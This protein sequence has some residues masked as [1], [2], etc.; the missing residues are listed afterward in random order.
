MVA[1]LDE[2][3]A[4]Q[5]KGDL[6]EYTEDSW[7]P[8][9]NAA[10][11]NSRGPGVWY[12]T[13]NSSDILTIDA[14]TG[15]LLRSVPMNGEVGH[16]T[17]GSF[18][19]KDGKVYTVIPYS[20]NEAGVFSVDPISGESRKLFSFAKASTDGI[21]ICVGRVWND[22]AHLIFQMSSDKDNM[23]VMDLQS[24][25]IVNRVEGFF[26][27]HVQD[28]LN[29][30]R[31]LAIQNMHPG[32]KLVS[33]DPL[34]GDSVDLFSMNTTTLG[35]DLCAQDQAGFAV[36]TSGQILWFLASYNDEAG[37]LYR[38]VF[39]LELATD[40]SSAALTSEYGPAFGQGTGFFFG[41]LDYVSYMTDMTV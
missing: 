41:R 32:I 1:H 5:D 12:K 25:K 13:T 37:D 29:K 23:M 22:G 4:I 6:I 9:C 39:E 21:G 14:G 18:N 8:G 7:M 10:F 31:L 11:D 30:E 15:R 20:Y 34:T 3:G 40:R 26:A 16:P 2:K 27:M 36:D 19:R 24:G 38:G 17:F 35:S 33:L 28:P